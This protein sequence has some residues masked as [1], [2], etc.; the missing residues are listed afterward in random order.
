M[1]RIGAEIG[2]FRREWLLFPAH[3]GAPIVIFLTGT[4]GTAEWADRETG[5]SELARREGFALAVPEALPPDPTKPP[6][7]LAN[8]PRWNDASWAYD[9]QTTT[10]EH[11]TGSSSGSDSPFA[12]RSS[13]LPDDVQFLTAVMD[14]AIFRLGLD[15]RNVFV[16]GFSNGAGMTFRIAAE[17][18]NR[19]AAIAPVAGHCWV[20][21]PRPARPVPT[22]YT[23]GARDLLL[24]LRGGDVRLPWRNRLVRR[25]PVADTLERWAR[26]LDCAVPPVAQR[27]DQ[28]VRV[29]RY[30][31]PVVF[32]AV[33]IEDLG[34]H[35]P[36][37]RAQLN[38]RVAGPPSSTVNATEMIWAFFKSVMA[39]SAS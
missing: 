21:D 4:G 34:H 1:E 6:S 7:L 18:A 14:D 38:P 27:D 9:Q 37:G 20:R 2:G 32:D 36:G 17:S 30:P 11:D 19:V 15:S 23:V 8:P 33:T 16:T 12:R 10:I 29:D 35:W 26:A 22:L 5:W 28:T 24:P 39:P 25:P 31:G 13:A 3:P